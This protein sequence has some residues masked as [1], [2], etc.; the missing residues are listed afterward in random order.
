MTEKRPTP[1]NDGNSREPDA[2]PA[3]G[4]H[5][6]GPA[7]LQMSLEGLLFVA[8]EPVSITRLAAALEVSPEEVEAA[9]A[10]LQQA[11]A[12]RGVRLQ[13]AGGRVQF[14]SAPEMASLIERFLGLELYSKLSVP[15]LEALSVVAYR[16]PATRAEVEAVRGVNSDSVLRTLVSKGLIEEVGR[17]NAVG[18]PILYGTTFEFLQF[19]GLQSLEELPALELQEDPSD[20]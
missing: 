16:Q 20:G 19:F 8:D 12:N 2:A 3:R 10:T 11:C 5:N 6:G 15:A 1:S 17:M 14:V 18:R 13:R 9:L 7:N 4:H